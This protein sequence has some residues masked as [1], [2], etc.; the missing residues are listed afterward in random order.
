MPRRPPLP[1]PERPSPPILSVRGRAVR[2]PRQGPRPR[3]A[4]RPRARLSRGAASG[5]LSSE[6]V[7]LRSPASSSLHLPDGSPEHVRLLL[8]VPGTQRAPLGFRCP[9]VGVVGR[10]LRFYLAS[11]MACEEAHA[12]VELGVVGGAPRLDPG[13]PGVL[14]ARPARPSLRTARGRRKPR[15]PRLLPA[16]RRGSPRVPLAACDA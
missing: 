11:G 8:C 7:V 13:P 2:T 9:H 12:G 10:C 16:C 3:T 4:G 15:S 5:P 14:D 1:E 6:R